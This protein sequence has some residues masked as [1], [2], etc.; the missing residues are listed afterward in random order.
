MTS[1]KYSK[2]SPSWTLEAVEW[3]KYR[4]K[5]EQILQSVNRYIDSEMQT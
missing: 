1:P 3:E 4:K 5:D 2:F